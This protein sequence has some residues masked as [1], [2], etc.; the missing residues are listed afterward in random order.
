MRICKTWKKRDVICYNF[1]F[2]VLFVI[3]IFGKAESKSQRE[4]YT[5]NQKGFFFSPFLSSND[6]RANKPLD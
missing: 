6:R 3:S 5:I 1:L 2:I 4:D